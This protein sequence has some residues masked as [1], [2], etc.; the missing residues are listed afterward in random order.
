M[1]PTA[2]DESDRPINSIPGKGQ[3]RGTISPV[4]HPHDSINTGINERHCS[5]PF[6]TEEKSCVA[7]HQVSV[8]PSTEN[9]IFGISGACNNNASDI[10]SRE[11]EKKIQQLAQHLFYQQTVSVR[12][13]AKFVGKAS[14]SQR[15]IQ[16]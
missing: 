1:H 7:T 11:V 16:F 6:R 15:V 2:V 3:Q 8:D 12:D 5:K 13:L 9:G 14:A 10:P 4:G